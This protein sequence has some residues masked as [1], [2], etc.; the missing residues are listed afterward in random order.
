M[1]SGS[2]GRQRGPLR[3]WLLAHVA[4]FAILAAWFSPVWLNGRLL[5]PMDIL[6]Q[7][8]L[9]WRGG[10]TVPN[11]H[12][13]FVSD[14]ITQYIPYRWFAHQSLHSDGFVGWNN[15][16][17]CGTPQFANTMTTP[18]DW[19]I[20]LHRWL[21]FWG[22]WHLGIFLQFWIAGAGMMIFLRSEKIQPLVGLLGAVCFA[23]N[24]QFIAWVYHRW[25]LG[26]FCWMPLI[27]WSIVRLTRVDWSER[28]VWRRLPR[29]TLAA[30]P[31][32]VMAFFGGSLQ[33]GVFV[34][35]AV[36]CVGLAAVL[37]AERHPRA[38]FRCLACFAV[39]GLVAVGIAWIML[40]PTID[41]FRANQAATNRAQAFG[42]PG[43]PM[44]PIFNLVTYPFFAFPWPMGAPQT[45]DLWKFFRTD[46]FNLPYIGFLPAV[47]SIAGLFTK[48]V[49][50]TPKILMAAG[51]LIP[52]TPLVAPLYHRFFLVGILGAVWSACAF[53]N[54]LRDD[55]LDRWAGK[56]A[57][58][59]GGFTLAWLTASVALVLFRHPISEK[60]AAAIRRST[61]PDNFATFPEWFLGRGERFLSAFPPWSAPSVLPWL[62]AVSGVGI[63][64]AFQRRWLRQQA[65][66]ALTIV[67]A[68][69]E[70][71]L[72]AER[73]V[74]FSP[75][76]TSPV[77]VDL[78]SQDLYPA[79]SGIAML[80]SLGS[81]TR[82]YT[83]PSQPLKVPFPPNI[84]AT[85]GIPALRG[86][87]SIVKDVMDGVGAPDADSPRLADLAVTHALVGTRLHSPAW[88]PLAEIDG[89]FLYRFTNPSDHYNF[90]GPA[91]PA[92]TDES[93]NERLLK[94]SNA[95]GSMKIVENWNENWFYR[96]NDGAWEPVTK[97]P[98][99]SM[100]VPLSHGASGQLE[101]RFDPFRIGSTPLQVSSVFIAFYLALSGM[102]VVASIRQHGSR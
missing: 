46:L 79:T 6:D 62:L 11:V 73:W 56:F 76:S 16:N 41:A 59:F 10:I 26:S 32:I 90:A 30:P 45:L 9:P 82:L 12:N 77:A 98:D 75:P 101:L 68:T 84:L 43:G 71:G 94:I 39:I 53:L 27:L 66:V 49:P 78:K 3:P 4:F 97:N 100:S 36:G 35:A 63:L 21:P 83:D 54:D 19:T 86:Y 85:F 38:W 91:R 31:L 89:L 14:A 25:A 81:R 69:L 61:I 80:R 1:G 92:V 51:F 64:L 24:F 52:L 17:Y 99:F 47:F 7:M 34:V 13:H 50:L 60:L 8:F 48:R 58:A 2:E 40:A 102:L 87:D 44:Q 5:A 29:A 67:L 57:A 96:L 20:Q 55:G 70:L 22:A 74:T 88:T 95:P 23:A 15:L 28:G 18:F 65:L 93:Q 72:L 42:Y 33:H 37:S